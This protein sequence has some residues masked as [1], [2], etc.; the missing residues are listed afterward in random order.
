MNRNILIASIILSACLI[1][2]SARAADSFVLVSDVDDTV[3]ITYVLDSD[4]VACN[5][6]TSKLIFAGMPDLYRFLLGEN[7]S[8]RRLM[9]LSGSPFIFNDKVRE[10][11]NNA[12]FPSYSLT[13]RGWNE[14]LDRSFDYKTKHLKELY[15]ASE[16]NNFILI[17]D[18]TEKDPEVYA[19]FSATSKMNKVLAIYIHRITGRKLPPGSVGFVTAYDIAV[20][21]FLAGRLTEKQAADVGDA[22]LKSEPVATFLPNFQECPPKEYEQIAGLPPTLVQIKKQIEDRI[23]TLCSSRTNASQS[24]LTLP[25]WVR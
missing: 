14:L 5:A 8:A 22:V 25:T 7:S 2:G 12:H 4:N 17:G 6:M 15:S 10:L 3:K 20:H 18:D 24:H 1:A 21:E 11:L 16:G 13:L 9:F 23:T 19:N